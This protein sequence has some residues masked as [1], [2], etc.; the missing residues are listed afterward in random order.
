MEP[1]ALAIDIHLVRLSLDAVLPVV[2][3]PRWIGEIQHIWVTLVW[4]EVQGEQVLV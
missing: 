1:A 2:D 3:N 4:S